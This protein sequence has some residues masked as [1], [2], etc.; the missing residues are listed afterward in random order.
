M[1]WWV[2]DL[3][4]TNPAALISWIIWVIGSI[5]LHEL[6]HGVAAIRCGDRTPIETG[7]MS[8][9][10]L[11]HMGGQSLIVFAVVG[12]A[13]GAMP[14][15][16]SRFRRQY[17]DA[18]VSFAGPA[19]NIALA[20]ISIVACALWIRFGSFAGETLYDNLFTFF[21]LGAALN[22]VLA[23]FNLL[24]IPPLDGSHILASFS[25][26]FSEFL[27]KPHSAV[28]ALVVIVVI[29]LY[30]GGFIFGFAFDA[31]DQ[32]VGALVGV[33]GGAS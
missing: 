19:L 2:A 1:G 27:R 13:W 32:A 5:T 6:A 15:N 14:V 31:T 28:I 4:Q 23:A 8:F 21:R 24:P 7:H 10:P 16:P 29:F 30:G 11:V 3:F 33:L 17:D 9:N 22:I 25:W 20:I 26:R 12:I 18:I